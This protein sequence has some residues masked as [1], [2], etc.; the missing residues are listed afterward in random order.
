MDLQSKD[1]E[2]VQL[3]SSLSLDTT[4]KKSKKTK[5]VDDRP[6]FFIR[7][8]WPCRA[9][10]IIPYIKRD[11]VTKILLIKREMVK[12]G[13]RRIVYEDFGG[14]TDNVDKN[15][16]DTISREAFEESNKIFTIQ[17]IKNSIK[18]PGIYNKK[19]KYLFY[20]VKVNEMYDPV[21]F[22]DYEFHDGIF[23]TVEWVDTNN[24]EKIT[25]NYRLKCKWFYDRAKN[26]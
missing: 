20:F 22:G 8:D 11:G 10:G 6:T 2:T 5:D 15:I 1:A 3:L 21:I 12:R 25:L 24:V 4:T 9:G 18:G 14:K 17:T 19:S 13:E 16:R 26:L 7:S 23:R